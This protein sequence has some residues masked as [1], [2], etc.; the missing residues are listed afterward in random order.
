MGFGPGALG[1]QL[2]TGQRPLVPCGDGAFQ[3]TGPEISHAPQ[4]NLNPIVLVMNNG[5][6]G[7]LCR[8]QNAMT[9]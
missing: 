2:G 7:I 6:W 1:A 4:H 9:C 3:M 8:L 5:G